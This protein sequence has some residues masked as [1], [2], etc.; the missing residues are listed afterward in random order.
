VQCARNGQ[1][2]SYL[3]GGSR[4]TVVTIGVGIN[5]LYEE[6]RAVFYHSALAQGVE[7]DCKP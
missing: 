5:G 2:T 4:A 7:P 1:V 3:T 6:A